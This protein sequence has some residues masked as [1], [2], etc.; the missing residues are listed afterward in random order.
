MKRILGVFLGDPHR[1]RRVR[2]HRRPRRQRRD[3]R[4]LRHEPGLGRASSA[5]SASSCTPRCAAGWRRSAGGRCSTSSASGSGPRFGAGQPRRLVLHQLAD[6]D[7]RD[8]RRGDRHLAGVE[9][10]LPAARSRSSP[11][12]CG[13]SSGGMPF[14]TMERVFGLLGLCLLVFVVAVWKIGPDW[15]ELWSAGVASRTCRRARRR[16]PTPTTRIALFGAAMTPYEVFFFSSGAVEEGW[17]THGPQRE[18]GQRAHR[19]PA[20]RAAVAGDHGLRPPRARA[21][22]HRRRPAVAGRPARSPSVARQARAGRRARR[23]LRRDV[24][25]RARDGAVGRLHRRPVL[26]LAVGQVRAGRAQASRFHVV[27]LAGDRRRACSSRSAA[28]TR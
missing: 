27:V 28:S 13:S 26:R 6:A 9:R 4:P 7:R 11:C 15:G 24:R 23:H 1:H 12:W 2:R 25:R 19:L 5:S 8:R 17:T 14:E 21:A 22:R 18:P 10:Q 16:S 3:R 20:R